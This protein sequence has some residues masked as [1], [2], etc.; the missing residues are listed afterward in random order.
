MKKKIFISTLSLSLAFVFISWTSGPKNDQVLQANAAVTDVVPFPHYVVSPCN[1]DTID[2]D[3]SVHT[4]MQTVSKGNG[5]TLVIHHANFSNIKGTSRANGDK[6]NCV[7]AQNQKVMISGTTQTIDLNFVQ[8][9]IGKG[10]VPNMTFHGKLTATIDLSTSPPGF[11]QEI[12][13][14]RFVCK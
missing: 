12:T 5:Q 14:E 8:N 13:M 7:S 1:G 11:S 10:S 6:Y 9:L 3:G 2:M 4:T